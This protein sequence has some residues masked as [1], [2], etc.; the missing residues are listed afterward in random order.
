MHG[1][2]NGSGYAPQ[3][4][5]EKPFY[6][7]EGLQCDL[8]S[9]DREGSANPRSSHSPSS[10]SRNSCSKARRKQFRVGPAKIGWSAESASTLG[11]FEDMLPREIFKF[12]FF[13]MHIWRF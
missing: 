11:G 6:P 10:L 7:E 13:K 8:D 2:V 9:L 4:T 3:S 1:S 5:Y 12:S